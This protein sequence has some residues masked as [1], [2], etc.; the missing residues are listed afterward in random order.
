MASG[1][2]QVTG[3]LLSAAVDN[4]LTGRER[5]ALTETLRS[6]GLLA[7]HQALL[8][9]KQRTQAAFPHQP[10]PGALLT[11]LEAEFDAIDAAQPVSQL[12]PRALPISA[13]W[14]LPAAAA[15]LLAAL[16]VAWNRTPEPV[17]ATA[18]ASR[19]WALSARSLAASHRYWASRYPE[20]PTEPESAELVAQRLSSQVGFPVAAPDLQRLQAQ[21]RGCTACGSVAPGH[22][23]A[24]FVLTG[25]NARPMS[26]FEIQARPC[27]VKVEGF[28]PTAQPD[29]LVAESDGVRLAMWRHEQQFA[30]LASTEMTTGELA[31]LAPGAVRLAAAEGLLRL[32]SLR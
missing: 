14:M 19:T 26:L 1:V 2:S 28:T 21:L 11:R 23:T 4:E 17:A 16:G 7:E 3:E 32:A 8:A 9:L 27:D 6:P 31:R 24:V 12:G 13:R 10:V 30:W 5:E 22:Q 18:M 15:A 25:P 20:Q 29:V